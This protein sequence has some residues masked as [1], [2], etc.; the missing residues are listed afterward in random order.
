MPTTDTLV[1]LQNRVGAEALPGSAFDAAMKFAL[2]WMYFEGK[3]C[4]A[5]ANSKSLRDF[6]KDLYARKLD[7]LRGQL[8]APL[9]FFK[10]RYGDVQQDPE[11]FIRRLGELKRIKLEDQQAIISTL[12]NAQIDEVDKAI[13]L[14]LICFRIRNNLFHGSKQLPTLQQQQELF[15]NVGYVLTALLEARGEA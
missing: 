8:D 2:L 7:Q 13:G 5:D 9:E 15:A 12:T 11:R 14:L 10:A 4:K 1:W 3:A 6:A